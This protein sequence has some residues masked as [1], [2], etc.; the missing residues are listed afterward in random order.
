MNRHT[1]GSLSELK[2]LAEC[3]DGDRVEVTN[4]AIGASAIAV[5]RGLDKENKL[6]AVHFPSLEKNLV[7]GMSGSS[8]APLCNAIARRVFSD[9][10]ENEF[11]LEISQMKEWIN[12]LDDEDK[13]EASADL[14]ALEKERKAPAF[15]PWYNKGKVC[16]EKVKNPD[17]T[18]SRVWKE[19]K[20]YISEVP[21]LPMRGPAKWDISKWTTAERKPF[22]FGAMDDED[23]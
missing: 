19:Y 2:C 13:E 11:A 4:K 17:F 22:E 15:K 23:E 9:K 1:Y 16:D 14:K 8:Y 5:L 7:D 21:T 12:G 6:D 10:S 18:L 3:D 20:D